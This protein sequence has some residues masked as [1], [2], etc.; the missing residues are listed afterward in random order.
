M[1][2]NTTRENIMDRKSPFVMP[3]ATR[4]MP[5]LWCRACAR[6]SW[7]VTLEEANQLLTKHSCHSHRSD[8]QED[9]QILPQR[10]QMKLSSGTLMICLHSLFPKAF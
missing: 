6:L 9:V 8:E 7:M 3:Q 2:M 1:M 4:V 5:Q 10:H